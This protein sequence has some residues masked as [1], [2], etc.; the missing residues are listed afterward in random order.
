MAEL[1]DKGMLLE[2]EMV[3]ERSVMEAGLTD[4]GMSP[5]SEMVDEC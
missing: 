3:D 1:T 2:S 5:K 4:E